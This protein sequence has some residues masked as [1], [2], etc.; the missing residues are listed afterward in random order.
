[1]EK[2]KQATATMFRLALA[3]SVLMAAGVPMIIFGAIYLESIPAL[4]TP[5]LVAGIVFAGGGFYAVPL[6]W[7]A[8]AGRRQLSSLI[9]AITALH[10]SD[11]PTLAAHLN[12]PPEEVRARL[13]TCFAKGYLP[14]YV[15]KE[16][17]VAPVSLPDPE[18]ELHAVQCPGCSAR[19]EFRGG[20]GKCP[21]C[22]AT[23]IW[24][25]DARP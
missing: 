12:L 19:F 11:V 1:M 22:G 16:D 13:D 2:I 3:F 15:R 21:Y 9:Y 14:G 7:V 23:Y 25:E 18:G 8:Y 17:A 24:D 5:L 10:L 20:H 4:G 6:L